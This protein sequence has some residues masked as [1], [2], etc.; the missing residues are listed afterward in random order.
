M[1]YTFQQAIGVLEAHKEGHELLR[2]KLLARHDAAQLAIEE[3]LI[4]ELDELI[5][6]MRDEIDRQMWEEMLA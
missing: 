1:P 3:A 2:S 5:T 6:H 4:D